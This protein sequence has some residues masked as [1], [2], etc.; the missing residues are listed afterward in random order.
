M[1]DTL[2]VDDYEWSFRTDSGFPVSAHLFAKGAKRGLCGVERADAPYVPGH[3][4]DHAP[5]QRC[6]RFAARHRSVA[7]ARVTAPAPAKSPSGNTYRDGYRDG[8]EAM[9]ALILEA[10][11]AFAKN[12]WGAFLRLLPAPGGK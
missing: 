3:D 5:C 1:P 8:A 2:N 12:D 6:E 11:A 9:K 7:A 10:S 4:T